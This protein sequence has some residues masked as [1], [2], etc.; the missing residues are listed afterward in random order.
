MGAYD[1]GSELLECARGV[2]FATIVTVIVC[3]VLTVG[4]LSGDGTGRA[5]ARSKEH[6]ATR[7]G[8]SESSNA[9]NGMG[10]QLR[11]VNVEVFVKFLEQPW[12]SDD[13][14]TFSEDDD[15]NVCIGS[16]KVKLEH[17]K[18]MPVRLG[19]AG[20]H[21]CDTGVATMFV[22]QQDNGLWTLTFRYVSHKLLNEQYGLR[23]HTQGHRERGPQFVYHSADDEYQE[24]HF[25]DISSRE[26]PSP[27]I[28]SCVSFP[29]L[30]GVRSVT[31]EKDPNFIAV[32]AFKVL[33]FVDDSNH[34]VTDL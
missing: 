3:L 1:G 14:K 23:E 25:W 22:D 33:S 20:V 24:C 18:P 15:S 11:A 17:N 7:R 34:P 8:A 12:E 13:L 2:S 28:C 4:L 32:A 21:V 5:A 10:V 27:N 6:D 19:N 30:P 16:M 31:G 9:G 26:T 29:L